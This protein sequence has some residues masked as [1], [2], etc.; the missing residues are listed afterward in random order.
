MEN[1][2]IIY[3]KDIAFDKIHYLANS[4]EWTYPNTSRSYACKYYSIQEAI[5]AMYKLFERLPS[6]RKYKDT[7]C[8]T[9][10]SVLKGSYENKYW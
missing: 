8:I 3:F 5:S 10:V 6:Y 4:G 7:I 9:R 1:R 2:Y